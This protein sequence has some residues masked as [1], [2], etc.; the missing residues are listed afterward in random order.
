MT[1][2]TINLGTADQGNG[3]PIRVAF[4]KVNDN[5]TEL[6]AALG[7]DIGGLN[8]GAF[9]F[10][11]S[12][13][14]TTDSTAIVID[15]ATT[16]TSNLTVGGDIL[17]ST[18]LGGNIGSP[19]QQWRSL[20]V[21]NNTIFLGGV[22]LSLDPETNELNINN[23][24]ISQRITYADIPNAP[25]D[26]SDLTDTNE[27]LGEG[28]GL[29][30]SDFGEGFTDSLDAGKI[31]TSKLYNE[32]PNQGLNNLY[33]LEVTN[34]GVVALPDGSIINGATLKTIAGNYAGIT[35]GP[36]SPAG[37]DEDSWVWVDN[38]GATIATKY[39]TD[40]YQWKFGNDGSL[41]LPNSAPILFGGNN[42]RIQAGQG[43]SISSDGGILV[44]VANE[45]WLFG[46]DGSI[47]FPDNTV[48]TTAY[49]GVVRQ[50][51]A[52]TADN[53]TL[54]FNTVEGRLYIKYSDV[55]VDAAP[56]VQPPPD[57]D[58]DVNSITFPDATV[59]TSAYSDRLI[60][61][62]WTVFFGEF[63]QLLVRNTNTEQNY[64]NLTPI[65]NEDDTYG[66]QIGINNQASWTFLDNGNLTLPGGQQIGGSDSTQ[67]IA[68]T[69]DRGTVLFGNTPE[70]CV[71]T[72]SSHFHIMRD[73]PTTVD[74]FFGDDFNYV[75]LPY[76]S[77]LTNVGV[78]IGTDATHL[79]SFGK[80]GNLT[81]PGDILSEGNINIEVNLS[82]STLRRWQF[83]EDGNLTLP[84]G[85]DILDINGNSLLNGGD[86]N[87]WIQEF[88]TS[89]GAADVPALA[90]SV[91]YLANGDVVAL[92]LHS[93]DTGG[94]YTGTYS[95]VARFTPNG[96]QV[97]SMIFKGAEFT[98]GWGL[99]VDNDSGHIY[100]AGW[101]IAEGI[102]P[103]NI[104]T[105]TKLDTEDGSINW[106]KSYDVGYENYNT[107]VDVAS[108]GSPVMV[109]Y[110][111]NNTDNQVVTT[112]INA[113]DGSVTWSRALDG[114]GDEEAYGMAVGASGEVVTVGWMEQLGEDTDDQMLVVKY[115][116]DGTI[117]WQ[118]SVTVEEGDDCNGADADIDSEGNI[119]VCGSFD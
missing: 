112:K 28:G 48:Q 45:Q 67:G 32:N 89:L 88:E 81:V 76:D 77:T 49:T 83:G 86:G 12:T 58:L 54:W 41:T 100:V 44:E 17:P 114:Q 107:V 90:M 33:V 22:P 92:L 63:G 62:N 75:K 47:E 87:I 111:Y 61:N 46:P 38:D 37:K 13:M 34:G 2:K 94:G 115:L 72:Q 69:T 43:F 3:D 20:Y 16:I 9:E 57:T 96:T 104:A 8:I 55:W 15:Q 74:L 51:T 39:S 4:S 71:P 113:T 103:Y 117:A 102:G 53:G 7:L 27:L 23:I 11:G 14:S 84:V 101:A 70:Q 31:T 60:N 85:G 82:D 110:A 1:Q 66:V 95:S 18:N 6:Y 118:K 65:E 73:D 52:P 108:D 19:T 91:E 10:T 105:L 40:N 42:C 36:A 35:A 26:V 78:Q 79:W 119:Y 97:W 30:I 24:P 109:G 25:T 106:S 5:F 116:S 50:D 29:S 21:S 99:A 64:F 80:D 59:Q 68:L 56:L 98:N 93:E